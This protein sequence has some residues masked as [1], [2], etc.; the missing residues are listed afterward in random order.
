MSNLIVLQGIAHVF[1]TVSDHDQ[2]YK[3]RPSA[4]RMH[5]RVDLLFQHED[6]G[7][8]GKV[9]A[10]TDDGTLKLF[11]TTKALAFEATMPIT[12]LCAGL[13]AMVRKGWCTAGSVQ[14]DQWTGPVENGVQVIDRA[15]LLDVSIGFSGRFPGTVVWLDGDDEYPYQQQA[16]ALFRTVKAEAERSRSH[17]SS[18]I[19]A[20]ASRSHRSQVP[21]EVSTLL[22]KGRS[23]FKGVGECTR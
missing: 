12:R 15:R 3:C 23:W 21:V 11:Q 9:Y 7:M 20:S 4:F 2:P 19:A 5:Q 14:F 10:T 6:H 1:E 8:G 22:A 18:P 17:P 13:A 16:R